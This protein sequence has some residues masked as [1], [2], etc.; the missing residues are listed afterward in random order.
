MEG[1]SGGRSQQEDLGQC[2]RRGQNHRSEHYQY[3]IWLFYSKSEA[4]DLD[5]E[6]IEHKRPVNDLEALYMLSPEPH[7][8]DC[9]MADF[10]HRRYRRAFLMWTA[11]K[12]FIQKKILYIQESDW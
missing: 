8:V 2:D 3:A 12:F 11:R 10:E 4:Y 9:L 1:A 5:I 7:I 6:Q